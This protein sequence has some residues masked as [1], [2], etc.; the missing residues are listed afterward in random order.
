MAIRRTFRGHWVDIVW[1]LGCHWTDIGPITD[2]E[3]CADIGQT[4]AKYLADCSL[5]GQWG[6]PGPGGQNGPIKVP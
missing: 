1:T 2:L 5:W 3:H 6:L 4:L